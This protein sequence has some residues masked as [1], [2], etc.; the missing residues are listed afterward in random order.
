MHTIGVLSGPA[1]HD[2]LAPEADAVLPDIG[3]IP[4]WLDLLHTR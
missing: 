2:D 1:R 4:D 3:A